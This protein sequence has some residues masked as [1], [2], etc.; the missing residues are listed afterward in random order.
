MDKIIEKKLTPKERKIIEE[1]ERKAESRPHKS[2]FTP[3]W[4]VDYML[5]T[6]HDFDYDEK[7]D[8]LDMLDAILEIAK[9][10]KTMTEKQIEKERK[11]MIKNYIKEQFDD[12]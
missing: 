5:E 11:S 8:A 2:T 1:I 4:I 12:N 6:F 9:Q 3:S 7:Q 10:C